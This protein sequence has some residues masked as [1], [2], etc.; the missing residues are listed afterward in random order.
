MWDVAKYGWKTIAGTFLLSAAGA[1]EVLEL[2]PDTV[3]S[4][5]SFFGVLLGGIGVRAAIAKIGGN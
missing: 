2:V 4:T 3:I 1:L 5:L